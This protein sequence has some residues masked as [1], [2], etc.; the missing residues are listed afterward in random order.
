MEAPAGPS[1][2]RSPAVDHI[3]PPDG[4]G[5][6]HADAR[7]RLAETVNPKTNQERELVTWLGDQL[8]LRRLLVLVELVEY[9]RGR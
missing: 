2:A 7:R 1:T 8:D 5:R 4:H 9:R 6:R 3:M